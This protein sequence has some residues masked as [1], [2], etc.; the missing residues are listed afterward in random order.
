M[1]QNSVGLS[2]RVPRGPQPRGMLL[3]RCSGMRTPLLSVN[4]LGPGSPGGKRPQCPPAGPRGPRALRSLQPLWNEPFSPG[5]GGGGCRGRLCRRLFSWS[6]GSAPSLRTG[7]LLPRCAISTCGRP[8]KGD[9][10]TFCPS[11]RVTRRRPPELPARVPQTHV[12]LTARRVDFSP[13]GRP[14]WGRLS[15]PSHLGLS[16]PRAPADTV[17]LKGCFPFSSFFCFLAER[18]VRRTGAG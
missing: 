2:C 13:N 8:N 3:E 9:L 12:T 7:G 4:P 1:V 6:G 16:S 15:A 10:W 17:G 5:P 11:G 18:G 14:T